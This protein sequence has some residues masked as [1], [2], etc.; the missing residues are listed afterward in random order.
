[1]LTTVPARGDTV[2]EARELLRIVEQWRPS[3][4]VLFALLALAA[5]GVSLILA[6]FLW[7]GALVGA[8]VSLALCHYGPRGWPGRR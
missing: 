5:A 7:A 4:G 8:A 1:M 2:S 3:F 6:G